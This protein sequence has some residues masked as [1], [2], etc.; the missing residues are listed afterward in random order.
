MKK[1]IDF[2]DFVLEE[3]VGLRFFIAGGFAGVTDLIFLYMFH[4]IL[5]IHYLISAILAFIIAFVVSFSL[6][7]FWTFKSHR[8]KTHKQAGL[9][10]L[11][12]LFSLGLN[13][14]CM[15]ALVDGFGIHVIISQIIAGLLVAI[16]SFSISRN[17]VFK[18]KV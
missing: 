13:T 8:E 3:Y 12:S 1:Y 4:D 16:V 11:T 10:L 2:I 15:Y 14:L 7:K 17:I 9:Y 6:H 5:S 18:Y